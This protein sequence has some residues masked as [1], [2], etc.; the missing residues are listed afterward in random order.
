MLGLTIF[1]GWV[2]SFLNLYLDCLLLSKSTLTIF[3]WDGLL[4]YR[5]EVLDWSKINVVSYRQNSLW[6]RV[7][8]KGDLVIQL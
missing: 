5:T 3:L 6:D 4:E 7:F 1:V 8:G 2:I